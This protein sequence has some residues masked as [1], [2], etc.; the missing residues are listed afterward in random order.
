MPD[1]KCGKIHHFTR[2]PKTVLSGMC[3]YEKN[4]KRIQLLEMT[5]IQFQFPITLLLGKDCF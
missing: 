4:R 2:C 5:V 1:Q 3:H